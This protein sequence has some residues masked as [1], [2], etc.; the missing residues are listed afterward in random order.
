MLAGY[1]VMALV[2]NAWEAKTV[3]DNSFSFKCFQMLANEKQSENSQNQ[4]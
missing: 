3:E 2:G 1:V 4:H